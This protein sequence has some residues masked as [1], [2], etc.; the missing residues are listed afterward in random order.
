MTLLVL[1]DSF[2]KATIQQQSRKNKLLLLTLLKLI[3]IYQLS[4]KLKIAVSWRRARVMEWTGPPLSC[5]CVGSSHIL[6]SSW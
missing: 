6:V 3:K 5:H 1:S 2:P 4:N